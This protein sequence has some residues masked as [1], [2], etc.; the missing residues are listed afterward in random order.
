MSYRILESIETFA[1]IF[2]MNDFVL[3]FTNL[4]FNEI[5]GVVNL[6]NLF[7]AEIDLK[8]GFLELDECEVLSFPKVYFSK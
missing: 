3:W 7:C 6:P 4:R 5:A 1:L 2:D 8:H